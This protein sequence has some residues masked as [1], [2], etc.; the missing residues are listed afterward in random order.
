[1]SF[2]ELAA[3]SARVAH[4]LVNEGVRP[5]DR[6]AFL[7][8]PSLPFYLSL[9]GAMLMGAISVPLFTLFGLDGLRLRTDDCTPRLLITN[10]EKAAIAN[11]L[12]GVRVVVAEAALLDSM[13]RF[14]PRFETR[15]RAGNSRV[16]PDVY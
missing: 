1:L 6:I 8:E 4:W 15:T 14:P 9:F 10:A 16:V 13:K 5:G 12:E 7:L 2:D 3:G 11:Q